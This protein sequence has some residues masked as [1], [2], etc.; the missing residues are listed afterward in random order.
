MKLGLRTPGGTKWCRQPCTQLPLYIPTAR[1]R[2]PPASVWRYFA[3]CQSNAMN[4]PFIKLHINS[5]F[6]YVLCDVCN[7]FQ[8]R[9]SLACKKKKFHFSNNTIL[10]FTQQ[11]SDIFICPNSDSTLKL[12]LLNSRKFLKSFGYQ[13]HI[14]DVSKDG[15]GNW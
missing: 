4:T 11:K 2:T 3:F 7:V 13:L 10:Q 12:P 15:G 1:Y 9:A 5:S 6:Y 14:G 8:G